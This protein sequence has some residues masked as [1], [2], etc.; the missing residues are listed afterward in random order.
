[1]ECDVEPNDEVRE[2]KPS[3][4]LGDILRV[5]Y[6]IMETDH[7]SG[8]KGSNVKTLRELSEMAI[9][10]YL[11][12]NTCVGLFLSFEATSA[13]LCLLALLLGFRQRILPFGD[14]CAL[15]FLA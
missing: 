9:M 11:A 12:C 14:L 7:T 5:K 2:R 3:T 10:I 13:L 4:R 1:M 15:N 6:R 8:K